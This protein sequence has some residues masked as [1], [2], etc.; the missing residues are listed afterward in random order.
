MIRPF[1]SRREPLKVEDAVPNSLSGTGERASAL[2]RFIEKLAPYMNDSS[3]VEIYLSAGQGIS[4]MSSMRE[5]IPRN[6]GWDKDDIAEF[7]LELAWECKVRLDPF[8]PF[9]GGVL[10][11]AAWRWHAVI[12]PV[13]PEGPLIVL[14]RQ[15]FGEISLSGFVFENFES[16]NLVSWIR[17][18]VSLI[19]YG[20]TGSG[21]TTFLAAVLREY[22]MDTRVGLAESVAEIPLL[23][24]NWFRLVEVPVDTGGRGGVEFSRVLAEMMRLSPALLVMGELRGP[25]AAMFIDF[26]RTG[27]GGVMT[28]LHAGSI[29]DV[30]NRI[31]RLSGQSIDSLPPT[32]GLRVWRD[33]SNVTRVR[34]DQ[35]AENVIT[36]G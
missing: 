26:A 20:A 23:S 18:G 32:V 24:V 36:S 19:I 31:S 27:H 30:R 3:V 21:K 11:W 28:T 16:R 7:L 2:T 5:L 29:A 34:V 13:S 12:S 35:V 9:A 17:S 33:D 8:K 25:E 1:R 6:E 10:P 14:R 15:L 4:V 22:F